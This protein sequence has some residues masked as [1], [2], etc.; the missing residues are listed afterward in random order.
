M[1][2]AEL[3]AAEIVRYHK[4]NMYTV[5]IY[6]YYS[7]PSHCRK[8]G[9]GRLIPSTYKILSGN[10]FRTRK[11]IQPEGVSGAGILLSHSVH[12]ILAWNGRIHM[13]VTTLPKS[14]PMFCTLSRFAGRL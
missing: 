3:D 7:C 8:L 2:C 5:Y 1:G 13:R 11:S 14:G 10:L 9:K 4:S 6:I 12:G